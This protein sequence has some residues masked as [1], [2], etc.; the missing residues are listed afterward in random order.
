MLYETTAVHVAG[1]RR[2]LG[3]TTEEYRRCLASDLAREARRKRFGN[4]P[5]D[6]VVAHGGQAVGCKA[7]TKVNAKAVAQH[8]NT[9][10]GKRFYIRRRAGSDLVS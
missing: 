5:R 6:F 3:L 10:T 7:Y 9:V 2:E 8:L 4:A 1:P